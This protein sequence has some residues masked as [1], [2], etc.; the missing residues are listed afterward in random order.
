MK[1]SIWISASIAATNTLIFPLNFLPAHAFV[2]N[3]HSPT[4]PL[5]SANPVSK[6]GIA[7]TIL[8]YADSTDTLSEINTLEIRKELES[9]GV[10]REEFEKTATEGYQSDT[11]LSEIPGIDTSSESTS[12]EKRK[13]TREK[14]T[15]KWEQVASIAKETL[16]DL[17]SDTSSVKKHQ[18]D[19]QGSEVFSSSPSSSQTMGNSRDRQYDIALEEGKSMRSSVLKRELQ[20]KGIYTGAFFEKSE[21]VKAYANA[22]VNE[23]D[24]KGSKTHQAFKNS[25]QE[26]DPSYRSVVLRAF[27]PRTLVRDDIIIDITN[28]Q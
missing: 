3:Y 6:V 19:D 16:S 8:S 4:T 24:A 1:T 27:D 26:F 13:K 25:Q 20:E 21:L 9:Y 7:T 28:Q 11:E 23:E 17:F 15:T 14:W 2:R 10:S 12:K 22:V 5:T 18:S